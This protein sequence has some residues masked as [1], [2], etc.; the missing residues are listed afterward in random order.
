M[1]GL[2]IGV[3]SINVR[4]QLDVV[5]R[6]AAMYQV[7]LVLMVSVLLQACTAY[8]IPPF[9]WK[10]LEEAEKHASTAAASFY[11][12]SLKLQQAVKER[13]F[14]PEVP[15]VPSVQSCE[16]VWNPCSPHHRTFSHNVTV[17][18]LTLLAIPAAVLL[19]WFGGV[20]QA[21]SSQAL[22]RARA[23]DQAEVGTTEREEAA[24][25]AANAI[26]VPPINHTDQAHDRQP[27]QALHQGPQL[28][29]EMRAA[30]GCAATNHWS[31]PDDS[32]NDVGNLQDDQC[33]QVSPEGHLLVANQLL[34]LGA[35][36]PLEHCQFQMQH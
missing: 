25:L 19:G 23:A 26:Q 34:R 7:K 2:V 31:S 10:A 9:T 4:T 3:A 16:P 36:P 13:V 5:L 35:T 28:Q 14:T 15:E 33:Q 8:D 20:K 11:A 12:E 32:D 17:L 18:L 21:E 30:A 1:H 29:T 24:R 6:T 22:Q 27:N